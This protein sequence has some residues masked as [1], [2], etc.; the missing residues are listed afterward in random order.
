MFNRNNNAADQMVTV[1]MSREEVKAFAD[2]CSLIEHATNKTD[3]SIYLRAYNNRSY[4]HLHILEPSETMEILTNEMKQ[5]KEKCVEL[6]NT[7]YKSDKEIADIKKMCS[8]QE[9]KITELE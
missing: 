3:K 4:G 2:W 1:P 7:V 6:E 5:E 8:Q 9:K